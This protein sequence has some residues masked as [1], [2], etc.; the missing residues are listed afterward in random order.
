VNPGDNGFWLVP[1][2]QYLGN[3]ESIPV[4]YLEAPNKINL[5]GNSYFYLE[6][7]GMNCIDE[8]IPF[9]VNSFTI[10]TN[11]TASVVKSA[12]AK[13][14]VTTTPLAQWFDNNAGPSKV[15]NPPAERIRRLRLKL[16]YHDGS[17]VELGKFD[18][19]IM[20]EFIL[21]RPQQRREYKMFVPESIANA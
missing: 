14:A 20:L 16:R 8:L 17:V 9:A 12:F 2:S 6:I 4:Y 7:D 15:Y 21:F 18:F 10:G 11:E 13:I 1:D 3:N 5:M 19:S